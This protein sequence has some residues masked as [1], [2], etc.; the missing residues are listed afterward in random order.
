MFYILILN[1]ESINILSLFI[2]SIKY[3]FLLSQRFILIIIYYL[4]H[5]ILPVNVIIGYRI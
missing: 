1:L 5:T 3:I 4:L 2:L